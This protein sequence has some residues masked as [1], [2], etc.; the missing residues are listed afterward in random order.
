MYETRTHAERPIAAGVIR[1]FYDQASWWPERTLTDIASMLERNGDQTYGLWDDNRLAAF[2]RLVTDGIFRGYVEDFIVA[3][4]Y[5]GRGLGK[6][7]LQE[8]LAQNRDI[9]IVSLFGDESLSRYYTDLG[10]R[11]YQKQKVFHY[12]HEH[13]A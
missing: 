9:H 7:F 2:C 1:E 3:E 6:Q 5:R 8:V 12:Y 11:C 10:F 13:G 4:A